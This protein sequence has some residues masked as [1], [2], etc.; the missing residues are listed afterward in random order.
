MP[1]VEKKSQTKLKHFTFNLSV[2]FCCDHKRIRTK[3][4]ASVNLK[5]K[6]KLKITWSSNK[7]KCNNN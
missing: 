1:K 4:F 2:S 5:N 7:L 6:V 3:T